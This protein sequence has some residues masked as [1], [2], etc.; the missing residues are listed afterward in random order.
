MPASRR[1]PKESD[2]HYLLRLFREARGSNEWHALYPDDLPRSPGEA[3]LE[4]EAWSSAMRYL[5]DRHCLTDLAT[6]RVGD[7]SLPVWTSETALT[8]YGE[9]LLG[10][11][12]LTAE[13]AGALTVPTGCRVEDD[14]R[15]LWT[16]E[17]RDGW[18]VDQGFVRP[19]TDM[20]RHAPLTVVR[21]RI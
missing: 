5:S 11:V 13:T 18:W 1:L 3:P 8:S 15:E 19:V 10:P 12:E 14:Q 4:Q 20:L 21:W 2:E 6:H 7:V 16:R 17:E 9:H